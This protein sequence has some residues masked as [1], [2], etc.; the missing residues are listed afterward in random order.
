MLGEWALGEGEKMGGKTWGRGNLRLEWRSLERRWWWR[1]RS[2]CFFAPVRIFKMGLRSGL[3][4]SV[5]AWLTTRESISWLRKGAE[6]AEHII[7]N[8]KKNRSKEHQKVWRV[9]DK[10]NCIS[11]PSKKSWFNDPKLCNFYF[12]EFLYM[13]WFPFRQIWTLI[14]AL[15]LINITACSNSINVLSIKIPIP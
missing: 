5:F 14:I 15:H 8:F 1:R 3:L 9:P 12:E 11:F 10:K 2:E 7:I 4:P 13:K 6:G